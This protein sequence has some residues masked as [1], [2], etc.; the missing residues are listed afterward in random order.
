MPRCTCTDAIQ[1][2]LVA[3]IVLSLAD[4]AWAHHSY[5]MF[6]RTRRETLQGTVRVLE[7][8]NPHVWVWVDAQD[9]TGKGTTYGFESSAPGELARFFGWTKNSL[10]PGD[11]ITVE[12]APLRSGNPGGALIRLTLADGRELPMPSST[13]PARGR[14]PE[15]GRR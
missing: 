10:K 15:P 8:T 7:W 11:R 5:S 13:A 2:V 9:E 6:D 1:R 4:R 14:G 12:Y 3:T